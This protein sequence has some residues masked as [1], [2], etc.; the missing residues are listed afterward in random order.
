MGSMPL[1]ACRPFGPLCQWCDHLGHIIID[2]Y[3]WPRPI[4][5]DRVGTNRAA[6]TLGLIYSICTQHKLDIPSNSAVQRCAAIAWPTIICMVLLIDPSVRRSQP[7][8][9]THAHSA[10]T[11][12]RV[13][14]CDIRI[15]RIRIAKNTDKTHP[16][17]TQMWAFF[18]KQL[19]N[20]KNE[21]INVA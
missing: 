21:L 17:S 19:K 1:T 3:H 6:P 15:S 16:N 14:A 5:I 11:R 18:K 20:E 7:E 4:A 12:T 10:Y 9:N 13:C 2:S 8:E